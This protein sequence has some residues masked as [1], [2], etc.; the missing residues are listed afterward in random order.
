[1]FIRASLPLIAVLA[2]A[3][4]DRLP[5]ASTLA[6]IRVDVRRVEGD[7]SYLAHAES[8]VPRNLPSLERA[9]RAKAEETCRDAFVEPLIGPGMSGDTRLQRES[10]DLAF[11]C[12]AQGPLPNDTPMDA[13]AIM[14]TPWPAVP[15]GLHARS[16]WSS[17]DARV[18]RRDSAFHQVAGAQLAIAYEACGGRAVVI[19]RIETRS[20]PTDSKAGRR[21][22]GVRLLYRCADGAA[23]IATKSST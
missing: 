5:D 20:E 12:V 19:E 8:R 3:G 17:Y 22:L 11:R 18:Q 23:P 9:L 1:M 7:G 21:L 14:D 15:D 13:A 16:A 6:E 10:L 4:C 2:V